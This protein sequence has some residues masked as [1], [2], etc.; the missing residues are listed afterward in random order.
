MKYTKVE[1][2]QIVKTFK[3]IQEEI[4]YVYENTVAKGK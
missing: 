2:E 4:A 3:R 1:V